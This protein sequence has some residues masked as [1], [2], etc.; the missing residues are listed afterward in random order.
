MLIANPVRNAL[1]AGELSLGVGVRGLRSGEIAPIMK[2][3]NSL[4]GLP[5]KSRRSVPPLPS[6]ANAVKAATS[7]PVITV[8]S[9]PC[10]LTVNA[11]ASHSRYRFMATSVMT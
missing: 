11:S 5:V 2:S 9:P 3:A 4:P 7:G 10:P 6:R 8:S 1:A